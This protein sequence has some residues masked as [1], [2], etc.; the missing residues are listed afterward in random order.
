MFHFINNWLPIIQRNQKLRAAIIYDKWLAELES[1]NES[2]KETFNKLQD[3]F[4]D[5]GYAQ[6]ASM[7]NGSNLARQGKSKG[8]TSKF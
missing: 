7:I 2:S 1:N 8:C 6:L 4:S 5:T 3:A